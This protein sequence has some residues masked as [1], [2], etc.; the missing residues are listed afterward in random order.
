MAYYSH[1]DSKDYARINK[2]KQDDLFVDRLSDDIAKGDVFPAVRGKRIDFYH[3][4]Q[5]LF[6]FN[7]RR[8]GTNIKY[9]VACKTQKGSQ[10]TESALKSLEQVESFVEGYAQIKKNTRLYKKPEA[11]HVS[12]LWNRHSAWRAETGPIVVLDIELSLSKVEPRKQDRIDLVLLDKE[13]RQLRFF[14]V[15]MFEN[16]DLQEVKGQVDVVGQIERYREQLTSKRALLV[17]RYSQYVRIL[18]KL[19]CGCIPAPKSIDCEVDLLVFGADTEQR[20]VLKERCIPK[21]GAQFQ[22]IP[23]MNPGGASQ[24]ALSTWW[25]KGRE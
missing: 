23:Y 20:R 25:R 1:W 12:L 4:G 21:F 24:K 6:S 8:F 22:C 10:V 18:N 7:G 5:K 2:L 13:S 17:D 16:R 3:V 9:A 15:K 14:E 11:E 19:F